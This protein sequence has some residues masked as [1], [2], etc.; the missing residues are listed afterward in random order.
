LAQIARG[1]HQFFAE[2]RN[3][4]RGVKHATG[5]YYLYLKVLTVLIYFGVPA[6]ALR[7]AIHRY[8]NAADPILGSTRFAWPFVAGAVV[9]LLQVTW[10][11][12]AGIRR[13]WDAITS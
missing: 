8:S 13:T 2:K 5:V 7:L 11:E 10:L 4:S 6:V 12:L 3:V 1:K 9:A